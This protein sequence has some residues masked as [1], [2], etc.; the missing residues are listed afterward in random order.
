MNEDM[1]N[2]GKNGQSAQVQFFVS[3]LNEMRK[4]L[5]Q[6]QEMIQSQLS[7]MF[8]ESHTQIKE[9]MSL[10]INDLKGSINQQA[11]AFNNHELKDDARFSVFNKFLWGLSAV[12]VALGGLAGLIIF[13][14]KVM[15]Y[16]KTGGIG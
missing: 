5:S 10:A 9:T 7:V 12:I 15:T 4:E 2:D 8:K 11:T 1:D 14:L 6:K 13:V 3:Q 16:I